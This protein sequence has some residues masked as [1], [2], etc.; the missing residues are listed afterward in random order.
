MVHVIQESWEVS[1]YILVPALYI[2]RV[3][4]N[5]KRSRH[6]SCQV[7]SL[8]WNN[9]K[10]YKRS[11]FMP[12]HLSMFLSEPLS[13]RTPEG[14]VGHGKIVHPHLVTSYKRAEWA[15]LPAVPIFTSCRPL[16]C[17]P[18]V[19]RWA[20]GRLKT[21]GADGH[22]IHCLPKRTAK[23]TIHRDLWLY[24]VFCA[25]GFDYC[26]AFCFWRRSGRQTAVLGCRL[27]KGS[28]DRVHIK[29]PFPHIP[30]LTRCFRL[31]TSLNTRSRQAPAK[32]VFPR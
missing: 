29:A 14:H 27:R 13:Y 6:I 3:K 25:Q 7:F 11:V 23:W 4:D 30:P 17:M 2:F 31:S 1:Y 9:L 22:P 26:L 20:S 21:Q 16:H 28:V 32:C 18:T 12:C 19:H 8:Q 5:S 10:N 24:R 15:D